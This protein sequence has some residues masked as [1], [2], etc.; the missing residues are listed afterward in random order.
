MEGYG[1]SQLWGNS[2]GCGSFAYM[3]IG[4]LLF[5]MT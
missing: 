4:E 1:Q 5:G 2:Y 3:E